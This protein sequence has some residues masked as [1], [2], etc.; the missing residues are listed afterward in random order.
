MR[1]TVLGAGVTGLT[2]AVRLLESGCQV[3]V[4]AAAPVE[5]STSY[6]AAAIWFPTHAGPPEKVAAWGRDTFTVSRVKRQT[7]SP[8]W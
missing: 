6:L 7:A 4:V 1:V 2:T 3:R 8:E 5:A